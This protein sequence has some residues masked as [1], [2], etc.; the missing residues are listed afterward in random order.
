MVFCL[1]ESEIARQVREE[2]LRVNPKLYYEFSKANQL[3]FKKYETEI[4][5]YLEFSFG[6]ENVKYQ[7]L[8]GKYYLD[9]VVF[10]EIHIEVDENGH[11]GYN[12]NFEKERE[13]YIRNNTKYFTTRYN[14][15]KQKPYELIREIIECCYKINYPL[16]FMYEN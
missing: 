2:L 12:E 14:P 7:V 16:D 4:K 10:D 15:Q 9:F 5:N 6:K 11:S 13:K 3:R 1:S 8:C